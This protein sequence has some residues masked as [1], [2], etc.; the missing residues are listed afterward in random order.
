MA[1]EFKFEL[2]TKVRDV[3]S[4][5]E[6]VVIGRTEWLYG[7]HRYTIQARG[8][9]DGKPIDTICCDQE[10]VELIAESTQADP[11]QAGELTGGPISAPQRAPGVKR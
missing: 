10:A 8:L 5:Y 2:G 3:I 1:V 6:G 9:K 7:C 11:R 4:G